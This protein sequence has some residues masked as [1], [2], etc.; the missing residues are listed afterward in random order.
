MG[1]GLPLPQWLQ[2]SIHYTAGAT[3][4]TGLTEICDPLLLFRDKRQSA[5]VL[6]AQI[7]ESRCSS[8]G[9]WGPPHADY[10]R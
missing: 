5:C 10:S 2:V 1:R 9:P 4:G 7:M 8:R 6:D 3:L